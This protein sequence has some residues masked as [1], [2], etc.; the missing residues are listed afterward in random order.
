[1]AERR[2]S[3]CL[4]TSEPFYTTLSATD[5]WKLQPGQLYYS[6][7]VYPTAYPKI[8]RI[9]NLDPRDDPR[10][11]SFTLKDF[12][13]P[14][15]SH[16]PSKDLGLEHDELY[17]AY[18][19]KRRLVVVLGACAQTWY[20]TERE[21][22]ILLCAPVFSFKERHPQEVVIR[23]Q[24][25]DIPQWFYLPPDHDGCP[26]ESAVRFEYIQ[27]VMGSC[28]VPCQCALSPR[29]PVALSEE[30]RV[31]LL[32]HL[33]QFLGVP[34]QRLPAVEGTAPTDAVAKLLDD[35]AAYR[36]TLLEQMPGPVG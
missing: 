11:A 13:D 7:A 22:R 35:I 30:A 19:G 28:L 4:I 31:L 32:V 3:D 26:D 10:R 29:L 6:H 18:V 27:P 9:D 24:A 36:Q 14:D 15:A 12:S 1:V 33:A 34:V 8:L 25:F 16:Y 5:G 2:G 20:P 21:Q 17:Y 23:T